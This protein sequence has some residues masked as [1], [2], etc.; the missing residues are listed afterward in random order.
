MMSGTRTFMILLKTKFCNHC[1]H[2]AHSAAS[3]CSRI[4]EILLLS[5]RSNLSASTTSNAPVHILL[6]GMSPA[7]WRSEGVIAQTSVFPHN[8]WAKIPSILIAIHSLLHELMT[9]D[10]MALDLYTAIFFSARVHS[11]NPSSSIAWSSDVSHLFLKSICISGRDHCAMMP[12]ANISCQIIP[13][14]SLIAISTPGV[15]V[16]PVQLAY[17]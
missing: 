3:R 4:E 2:L 6:V 10:L 9:N 7:A 13:L 8:A 16:S 1:V 14:V 15:S 12:V 17:L 11:K 5:A